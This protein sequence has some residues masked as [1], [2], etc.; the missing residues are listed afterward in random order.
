MGKQTVFFVVVVALVGAILV[1]GVAVAHPGDRPDSA[2]LY[3]INQ[4][5]ATGG[6][7]HL[8][9]LSWQVEGVVGNDHYRLV[10]PAD[11]SGG[12]CCT[13]LPCLLRSP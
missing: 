11:S 9:G 10:G 8:T 4:G 1:G 12:C 3:T 2:L 13:Y 6:G 5:T 7:Y